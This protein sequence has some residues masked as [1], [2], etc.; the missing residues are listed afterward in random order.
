M[1]QAAHGEVGL[2]GQDH[3][4]SFGED[5]MSIGQD[6]PAELPHCGPPTRCRWL[7]YVKRNAAKQ[8]RR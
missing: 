8:V 7:A 1:G 2:G 6:E 5:R 4:E 3:P